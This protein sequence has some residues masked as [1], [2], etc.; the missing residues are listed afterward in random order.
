MQSQILSIIISAL[1]GR[2]LAE[3]GRFQL[4]TIFSFVLFGIIYISFRYGKEVS[5]NM[6]G[7]LGIGG[8]AALFSVVL[9]LG[10]HIHV[11]SGYGGLKDVNYITPYSLWDLISYPFLVCGIYCIVK[12]LYLFL[13]DKKDTI[14][15]EFSLENKITWKQM[16]IICGL[17]FVAWLPYFLTYY[18]GFIFA[19]TIGSI[20]EAVGE[21]ALTNH[22]PVFYTLFIK[23]CLKIGQ[24]ISDN[25]LGC[26]IYT[27]SQM[28]YMSITLGYMICWICS[29]FNRNY[30]WKV[31]LIIVYGCTPYFAQLSIAM[32]KDPVFSASI[33]VYTL[34]LI[35]FIF[36]KGRIVD[37]DKLYW[38]K[39]VFFALMIIFTRNNGI[40]VVAFTVAGIFICYLLV[41]KYEINKLGMILLVSMGVVLVSKVITG[42]GY[43][44]R[45]IFNSVTESYGIFLNQ[46]ARVV[47]YEG[48]MSE[49]DKEYMNNLLPLELYETTYRPCCVDLLKFNENFR[50][51]YLKEDFFKHYFSMLLKNPRLYFESWQLQTYGFWTVNQQEI[52]YYSRN[53]TGAYPK[54]LNQETYADELEHY[55]LRVENLLKNQQFREM[56]PSVDIFVPIGTI[57]W[58][59]VMVGVFLFVNEME[60]LWLGLLPSVGVILTLLVASPMF[61]WPRYAVALQYLLPVYIILFFVKK[62]EETYEMKENNLSLTYCEILKTK[63]NV[64]NMAETLQYLTENLEDLRGKYICVSNVHTT[65]MSYENDAYRNIQNSAAMVLPDGKPLSVVS[66]LWGFKEAQKVSGPDLMSEMFK[67]SEEKGYTHYFYGSTEETLDKLKEAL[68]VRYPKLKIAGMYSPPF[69]LLTKE[70]DEEIIRKIN[71]ASPDFIWVGLG[72][73]KQEQWMDAHR[74]RLSGVMLG[75]G[76]GF[77]FHAGTVKRAPIWMQKCGLE[78][79]HRLTQD[80]KR[81]FKRYVITNTKFLWLI[82]TGK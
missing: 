50:G 1:S 72:A 64:T 19:D 24:G 25:T 63:I 3:Y 46:M 82:L 55:D 39:Y 10:Y 62:Q 51:D 78:W 18:P 57:V 8:F 37:N 40:Y 4:E 67:L 47:T 74:D 81:L 38:L 56:F 80:P 29:R 68:M 28:V 66:R 54:N 6:K 2:I 14:G 23:V 31:F 52:N 53:I 49:E 59:I 48:N 5:M 9:I 65:V 17:L 15:I 20:M 27:V 7:K 42:P 22:H 33:V 30:I 79:L 60:L 77:D 41:K 26:A 58:I 36:S 70:E 73:P 76:A 32:W 16:L 21:T 34:L 61:Y 45:G 13:Q 69:R 71:D 35:D 75:V 43:A 44:Y 12:A 11:E